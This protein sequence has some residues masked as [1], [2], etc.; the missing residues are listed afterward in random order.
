MKRLSIASLA[1]LAV[2][3]FAGPASAHFLWVVPEPSGQSARVIISETLSPDTR[4][5]TNI[6][7]GTSLVWNDAGKEVPLTLSKANPVPTV[8]LA[9]SRGI[10]RGHADLGARTER[11][12]SYRLHYYP[13]A[14]VGDPF[15]TGRGPASLPIEIVPTGT[16]GALRLQVLVAGVPAKDVDVNLLMPDGSESSVTT[17]ADGLTEVLTA[18]GRYGAWARHWEQ[19]SGEHNGVRYGHTRHYATVVFDVAAGPRSE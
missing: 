7:S 15:A 16:P 12:R 4:V 10:V 17:D 2:L 5:D 8:P 18:R 13:K 3:S 6:V 9:S 14:I 11:D 1:V 19:V